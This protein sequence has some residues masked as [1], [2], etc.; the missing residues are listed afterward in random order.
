MMVIRFKC[1]KFREENLPWE[2]KSDI[3]PLWSIIYSRIQNLM[4]VW[5]KMQDANSSGHVVIFCVANILKHGNILL[6]SLA[7]H[8]CSVFI[9][10]WFSTTFFRK[11]ISNLWKHTH[12]SY[13]R[14]IWVWKV[15]KLPGVF[16]RLW[17]CSKDW[18]PL[19]HCHQ[20]LQAKA[21]HKTWWSCW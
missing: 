19:M 11:E 17:I 16:N 3:S 5:H 6:W 13:I 15:R 2:R 12:K 8:Y 14:P 1:G 10:L 7:M 20:Y 18:L 9:W 21:H 4:Y